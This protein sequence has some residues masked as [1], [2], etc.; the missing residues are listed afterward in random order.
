M[1]LEMTL[2]EYLSIRQVFK[3]K[4]HTNLNVSAS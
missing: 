1:L 2:E 3:G 4:T